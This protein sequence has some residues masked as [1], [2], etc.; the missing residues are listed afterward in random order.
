MEAFILLYDY[1]HQPYYK[2][3]TDY[4]IRSQEGGTTIKNYQNSI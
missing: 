1:N 4:L 3:K 2:V